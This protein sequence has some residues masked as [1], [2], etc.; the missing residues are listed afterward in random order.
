MRTKAFQQFLTQI[1]KLTPTQKKQLLACIQKIDNVKIVE[2]VLNTNDYCHHCGSNNFIKWG[3]NSGI[4][5]YKCKDCKKTFNTLTKTPMAHLRYKERW[6]DY[7]KD[8]I[9]SKS[10]RDSAEHCH[11]DKNTSFK[12]RHRFLETPANIKAKHLHGIVEF[13]ETYFLK[14]EKGN[15]HLNRKPHK[16]G[17]WAKQGLSLK[18]YTPVLIARDRNGNTADFILEHSD[19]GS[20]AQVLLPILDHDVLLCSDSKSSYKS[21]A[22]VFDF[23]HKPINA[24]D[25]EHVIE[26]AYHIQNVNAYDS[27]LKNWMR[28]FHGVSTKYL[29]NY[30]GWMRMLDREKTITST[31]ILGY[32]VGTN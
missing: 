21:F 9:D 19:D 1:T 17:G 2:D 24:S 14:S 16:R 13:D 30:L 22:D 27:R 12:W 3:I 26:G 23:T 4:Q 29:E 20:I 15:H 10:I 18:E 31:D 25:G 6:N 28:R 8:L 7:A 11:I 32:S 5:R